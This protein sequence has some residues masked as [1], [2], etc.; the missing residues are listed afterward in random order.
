MCESLVSPNGVVGAIEKHHDFKWRKKKKKTQRI[1]IKDRN[2]FIKS[3]KQMR[4]KVDTTQAKTK[5]I[6]KKKKNLCK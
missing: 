4:A 1:K 6:V 5:K 3:T 2:P